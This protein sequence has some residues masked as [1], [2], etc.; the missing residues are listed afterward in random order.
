[1]L[2]EHR[3]SF[4]LKFLIFILSMPFFINCTKAFAQSYDPDLNYI[5]EDFE[6]N[7]IDTPNYGY[8]PSNWKVEGSE[9]VI[10]NQGASPH[11]GS[12]SLHA[13]ATYDPEH[14]AVLS[15]EF[16]GNPGEK[17]DLRVQIKAVTSGDAQAMFSAT[18]YTQLN[19]STVT[20]YNES[21]AFWYPYSSDEW[22]TIT[23]ENVEI[24]QDGKLP[25]RLKFAH[26][27]VAGQ[28]EFEVDC[29]SSSLRFQEKVDK[30]SMDEFYIQYRTHENESYDHNSIWIGL[31]K[32]DQPIEEHE[33]EDIII[34]DYMGNKINYFQKWFWHGRYY[35]YNCLSGD[36]SEF[37]PFFESGFIYRLEEDITPGMYHFRVETAEGQ[38]L[39]GEIDYPRKLKLPVVSSSSMQSKH[40]NDDLVLYWKNPTI[41]SNWNEVHELRIILV[42]NM[43]NW[44]VYSA[45]NREDESLTIPT[46]TIERAESL[47]DTNV[48]EWQV[49]TRANSA[50]GM[51]YARGV[52]DMKVLY[53]PSDDND[54]SSSSSSGCFIG[55]LK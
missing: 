41:Q 39:T 18:T 4:A 19:G 7:F 27:T 31:N 48:A 51:N 32:N 44:I 25:I 50:E 45:V 17:V 23:L 21:T 20:N 28:T 2:K 38:T 3:I 34:K 54:D 8:L 55:I 47:H 43:G 9:E 53:D 46:S 5:L 36:C 6:G 11:H 13:Q 49:Q 52:S 37:G 29:I 12:Y 42:D 35:S 15:N 22:R 40:E 14:Y 1:M 33:I 16:Q 26:T 30:F 24:P 10:F